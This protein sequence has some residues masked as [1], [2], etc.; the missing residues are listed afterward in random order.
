MHPLQSRGPL[1]VMYATATELAGWMK[2]DLDTYSATQALTLQSTE[3]SQQ[4]QTWFAATAVTG[5][6]VTVRADMVIYLPNKHVTAVAAVRVNGV[7]VTGWTLAND[8]LYHPAG[9]GS[10]GSFPPDVLAVDYTHGY[11]SVPDDVKKAVLQMAAEAYDASARP[12]QSETIDDYT[13]RYE[14]GME[15]EPGDP[16]PVVAARYRGVVF[17]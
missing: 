6:T 15:M 10:I 9:F 8:V 7:T 5:Y 14:R 4:A 1:M 2:Q 13:V 11:T 12:V 16:W 3:F 17:A